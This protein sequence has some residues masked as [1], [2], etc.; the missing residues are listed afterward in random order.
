MTDETTDLDNID[1]EVIIDDPMEDIPQGEK[2]L[3]TDIPEQT[4]AEGRTRNTPDQALKIATLGDMP[5]TEIL[6]NIVQGK[7]FAFQNFE[8]IDELINWQP[9]LTFICTELPI[10]SNGLQDD[11]DFITNI[12]KLEKQTAGGICVKCVLSPDTMGRAIM[13]LQEQTLEMRFIYNPELVESGDMVAILNNA[14][15]HLVAGTPGAISAHMQFFNMTSLYTFNGVVQCGLMEGAILKMASTA[16]KAVRQ[17]F[18]NQLRDV[19][20]EYQVSPNVIRK[21]VENLKENLA[22]SVPTMIRAQMDDVTY[23]KAKS[24]SGEYD[25][26]DVSVFV[27]MTDKMP[28]LDECV[29]YRNLKK[30]S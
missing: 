24:F 14:D 20:D 1:E 22:E 3:D 29:N 23:K 16:Y 9:S 15:R 21:S 17:T 18:F 5:F 30:E 27:G 7:N 25:N 4:R 2:T 10:K 26:Y 28:L 8:D 13:A 19:A 12:Q 6:P 11:V